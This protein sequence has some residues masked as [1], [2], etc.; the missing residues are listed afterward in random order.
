MR[1]FGLAAIPVLDHTPQ[2]SW[3]GWAQYEDGGW[4]GEY[5]LQNARVQVEG[6]ADVLRIQSASVKLSPGNGSR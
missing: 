2:G 1:S 5:E 6:L 4:S 3:R